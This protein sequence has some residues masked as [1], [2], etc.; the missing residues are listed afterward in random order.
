MDNFDSLHLRDHCN[1]DLR[2]D[3]R[4]NHDREVEPKEFLLHFVL[5]LKIDVCA[6]VKVLAAFINLILSPVIFCVFARAKVE[7]VAVVA[8]DGEVIPVD[9]AILNQLTDYI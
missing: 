6:P 8:A 3:G 2:D 5:N 4:T 7:V 1:Y 9:R